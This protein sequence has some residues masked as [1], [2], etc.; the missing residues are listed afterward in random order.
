MDN[1]LAYKLAALGICS[2][3]DLAEK[4]TDELLGIEDMTEER[5]GELIMIARAPWFADDESADT[6]TKTEAEN[7]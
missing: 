3:E 7:G 4:A 6:E 5:A 2:M 1:P